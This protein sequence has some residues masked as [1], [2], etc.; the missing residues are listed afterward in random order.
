MNLQAL[1][2]IV[3]SKKAAYKEF[4]FGNDVAVFKVMGKMFALISQKGGV[5]N[6]NLKCEPHDALGYREI[7]ECV[8]P[9]YHMNKKHWNTVFI[10]GEM[11]DDVLVD[12]IN[13]S[14]E[15]VV[16]KLTKK[17]KEVLLSIYSR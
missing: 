7:Y 16:A 4:P 17:E 1:E 15:L 11:K 14:Y 3:L 9:G 6:I 13:V 5:V 12:M 10:N 2:E 8:V